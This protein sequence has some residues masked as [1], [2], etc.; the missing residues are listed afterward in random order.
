M[1]VSRRSRAERLRTNPDD[2]QLW[3]GASPLVD[4][5][6]PKL[7][8]RVQALVQTRGN[9]A[10]K[11]LT[12]YTF[13]RRMP[14]SAA[15]KWRLRSAR[16]VLDRGCGD[17]VDKATL[18][19]TL[20]R[21]AGLPARVRFA[22]VAREVLRGLPADV[23]SMPRPFVEVFTGARWVC[24][25]TYI[26]DTAYLAAARERLRREHA[27]CGYGMHAEGAT[28]WESHRDAYLLGPDTADE[29]LAGN[30][31][32]WRDPLEFL[33]AQGLWRRA[34]AALR[35]LGWCLKAPQLQRTL[36]G[37]RRAGG[38]HDH[39]A[40][41]HHAAAAKPRRGFGEPAHFVASVTTILP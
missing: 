38:L 39:E 13:V 15:P 34:G 5:G 30:G 17:A 25:D 28:L 37:I 41:V 27:E 14:V 29:L 4:M 9:D 1:A 40:R 31:R 33:R 20:L 10:D 18:L 22:P 35:L 7:R 23:S 6:D 36:D 3:K 26:F 19:L 2:P 21:L 8:L 11:A 24:T 12:L 32:A 16:E